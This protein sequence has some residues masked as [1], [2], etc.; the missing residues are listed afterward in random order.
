[1]KNLIIVIA[2][3]LMAAATA[4][5]QYSSLQVNNSPSS[6]FMTRLAVEGGV[7]ITYPIQNFAEYNSSGNFNFTGSLYAKIVNNISV[8][9]NYSYLDNDVNLRHD[10][11]GGSITV[12]YT[13]L[14][15]IK[16]FNIGANYSYEYKKHIPFVEGGI[17]LYSFTIYQDLTPGQ[18]VHPDDTYPT[19][20]QFGANLGAGYR[21]QF[22]THLGLFVKGKLHSF[23][24]DSRNWSLWNL[25]GGVFVKL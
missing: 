13:P 24:Y 18:F 1:M 14:G 9:F 15:G 12:K 11:L 2:I 17:G 3:T 25:S 8:Y 7:N 4:H 16:V 5:S 20:T 22:D 19:K 6:N 21:Y 10:N 23:S